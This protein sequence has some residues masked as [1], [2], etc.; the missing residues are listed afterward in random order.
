M[1]E[2]S[3]RF[4]LTDRAL[5]GALGRLRPGEVRYL[6]DHEG[7]RSG[8]TLTA[9]LQG[10]ATGPR[11][12]WLVRYSLDGRRRELSLGTYPELPLQH[13]RER[14]RELA[15][16]YAAGERDLHAV[17]AAEE[18]ARRRAREEAARERERQRLTFGALLE[19]Y[20]EELESRGKSRWGNEVRAH[21]R[22]YLQCLAELPAHEVGP[23]ELVDVIAKVRE[24]GLRRTADII[25]TMV[26]AAYQ[27]ALRA[28]YDHRA[29]PALRRFRLES[30]PAAAL[31]AGE[32]TRRERVL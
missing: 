7:T 29:H 20:A 22:R 5:R 21:L 16:R 17:V 1:S 11:A 19:A 4:L 26:H 14:K 24:R 13:A 30:N 15:R 8:V 25:R 2:S 32:V 27:A 6:T 31:P 3:T 18:E 12:Y 23:E 9:K 28:P 10:R